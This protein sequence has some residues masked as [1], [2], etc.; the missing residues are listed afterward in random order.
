MAGWGP[1]EIKRST[2]LKKSSMNAWSARVRE[3]TGTAGRTNWAMYEL[4]GERREQRR[5]ASQPVRATA[6]GSAH[7]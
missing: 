4:G 6:Q 2:V 5:M 7:A 3:K 1:A